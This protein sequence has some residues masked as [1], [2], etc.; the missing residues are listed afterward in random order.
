MEGER[1]KE[2]SLCGCLLNA[3]TGDLACN[4]GMGPNWESKQQ[5]FGLQTG[6]QSTEPHQPELIIKYREFELV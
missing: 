4:P 3:P 2:T 1:G 5:P 6:T